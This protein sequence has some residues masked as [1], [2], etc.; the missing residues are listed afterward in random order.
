MYWQFENHRVTSTQ[1]HVP[2]YGGNFRQIWEQS[3]FPE[4]HLPLH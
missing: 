1:L 3:R 2:K 4:D